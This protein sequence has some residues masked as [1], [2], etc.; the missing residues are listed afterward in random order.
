MSGLDL[1]HQV[2]VDDHV[3]ER[4]RATGTAVGTFFAELVDA[5]CDALE[6]LTGRREGALHDPCAVLAI[7]H[8]HLFEFRPRRVVVELDGTHTRGMTV[9]DER[10]DPPAGSH[11]V[12]E[13][14]YVADGPAVLDLVVDAVREPSAADR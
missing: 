14:G 5:Y 7:T 8:P 13:V 3:A 6:R 10:F 11:G 9:V 4:L 12:V 2:L 1:T